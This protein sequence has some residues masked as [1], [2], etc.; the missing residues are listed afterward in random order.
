[1]SLY[2]DRRSSGPASKPYVLGL[3][4]FLVFCVDASAQEIPPA[5]P[6]PPPP[7]GTVPPIPM[8]DASEAAPF[9]PRLEFGTIDEIQTRIAT[10]E[11]FVPEDLSKPV[12]SQSG[13]FVEPP[14]PLNPPPYPTPYG[15]IDRV[16]Y[17]PLYFEQ[18]EMERFGKSRG[19]LADSFISA[20]RFYATIPTL[21]YRMVAD[22]PCGVECP[23]CGTSSE[24]LLH[25]HPGE[26]DHAGIAVE[27]ATIAGLILLIP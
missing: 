11:S 6:L 5:P 10:N 21:P 3:T 1:M 22:P 24:C 17:Q 13:L 27:A 4:L 9:D 18:R 20:G 14:R 15:L 26:L 2:R 25:K 12:L 16:C 23:C 19:C 7:S 8:S